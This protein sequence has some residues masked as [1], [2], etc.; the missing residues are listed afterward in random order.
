MQAE[1]EFRPNPQASPSTN[2]DETI[3]DLQVRLSPKFLRADHFK[4]YTTRLEGAVGGGF[5]VLFSA[6][7]Q[8][9]KTEVTLHGLAWLIIHH[10]GKRHAYIT[11]SLRR[12]RRVCK[13]V[14]RILARAG[15]LAEGTLDTLTLPEGGQIVFTSIEA[16]ITGEPVD[17]IAIIDD[18]Y[19]EGEAKSK[20]RR[21]VVDEAYRQGIE[22][23]VHPGASVFILATRWHEKDLT[24]TLAREGWEYINLPAVAENDND[25]NG[26]TVGE[27]LFPGLWPIDELY[28][29]KSK[30]LAATWA[31]LFQGRPRAKG[32]EVFGEP[33]FYTELPKRY[34]VARGLDLAYTA[35]TSADFSVLLEMWREDRYSGTGELKPFFYIKRVDRKQVDA[36]NFTLTLKARSVER[37]APMRWYHAA[38]PEKGSADFIRRQGVPIKAK[39]ATSDKLVRA[40]PFAAAW[41]DDRVFVPD[42][43]ACKTCQALEDACPEHEWVDVFLDEVDNFT[44]VSDDYDDQI[45]AGAAAYDEL[46]RGGEGLGAETHN[47]GERGTR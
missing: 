19:K 46:D 2:V 7:P 6:P 42:R 28:K 26:R 47:L 4:V 45:D 5:R 35:K 11:F 30:V 23:R 32:S 3:L 16:G 31:S 40:T 36:P 1:Q 29:K 37:H 24:G 10:P 13:A 15:V 20:A 41:N 9:G 21:E 39:L 8:H 33:N 34:Q 43:Y 25:P 12:A 38:G 18:P 17:G 22:T 27:A 44:G 14:R